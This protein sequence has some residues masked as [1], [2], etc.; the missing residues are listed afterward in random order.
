MA[1]SKMIEN[2]NE[3][4]MVPTKQLADVKGRQLPYNSVNM[5]SIGAG[6][7]GKTAA[8]RSVLGEV[9][10]EGPRDST[11]GAEQAHMLAPVQAKSG[12]M[13][14]FQ[15]LEPTEA[16]P[17][18]MAAKTEADRVDIQDTVAGAASRKEVRLDCWLALLCEGLYTCLL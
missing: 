1:L 6:R 14:N 4:P 18:A 9:F 5:V 12:S 2:P 8:R 15:L 10:V 7:T 16:V 17:R 13:V 3:L 11:E